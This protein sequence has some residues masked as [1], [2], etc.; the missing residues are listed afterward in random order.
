MAV[1]CSTVVRS[2]L[3]S[4]PPMV[5]FVAC[6]LAFAFTTLSL[7]LYVSHSDN[8]PNPDVLSWNSLLVRIS[9]LVSGFD[10]RG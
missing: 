7:S 2:S 9:K 1:T 10:L 3:V 8:I 5:V 6:L 4:K